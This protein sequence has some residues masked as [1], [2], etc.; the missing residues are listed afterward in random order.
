MDSQRTVDHLRDEA[1]AR[2][3]TTLGDLLNT[4]AE[5]LDELETERDLWK[6]SFKQAQKERDQA[7]EDRIKYYDLG[8]NCSI[9]LRHAQEEIQRLRS[10]KS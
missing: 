4:A 6:G 10:S 8:H 5:E 9:Q 1:H 3:D 2:K 7:V